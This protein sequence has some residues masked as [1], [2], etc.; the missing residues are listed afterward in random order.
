MGLFAA[1]PEQ[2][3]FCQLAVGPASRGPQA[4]SCPT[5][6]CWNGRDR[7]GRIDGDHPAMRDSAMN[8]AN[9]ARRAHPSPARLPTASSAS[10]PFCHTCQANQ[11]L[12]INLLATYL[13]DESDPAY[14]ERL[15]SLDAYRTSLYQR[16][17]PVCASCQPGVDA[18]LKRADQRA[19]AEAFGSALKRGVDTPRQTGLSWVDIGVWRARSV[20]WALDIFTAMGIGLCARAAPE[21]L[22]RIV[23]DNA[24][25]VLAIR[26][27]AILWAVWDPTWLRAARE[28]H[29]AQGRRAWVGIMLTLYLLRIAV[30]VGL[31]FGFPARWIT[32]AGALDITMVIAALT[33]RRDASRIQLTLVRPVHVETRPQPSQPPNH[34]S[35]SKAG[36]S[37]KPE[38]PQ[39]T[40]QSAVFGQPSLAL[41]EQPDEPMDWEPTHSDW[42]GFGVGTQRMFAP[43]ESNETGLEALLATWGLGGEPV[44]ERP[45][46][47]WERSRW[48]EQRKLVPKDS[49]GVFAI[50]QPAAPRDVLR[51]L[52]VARAALVA[53]RV[54]A[55]VAVLIRLRA[56]SA[57]KAL[58]GLEV[59]VSTITLGAALPSRSW[60]LALLAVDA[61]VRASVL[62]SPH[63]V[64]LPEALREQAP[65]IECVVWAVADAALL[66]A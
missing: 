19:Q 9:F 8:E 25:A 3:Y 7:A 52:W 62:L 24:P 26:V 11:T 46:S 28:G 54:A 64:P 30:V 29:P 31:V 20:A 6:G 37:S 65:A 51:P 40:R 4:W 66:L 15:A 18:G 43:A 39:P 13:P 14:S 61:G 53:L 57:L 17:P 33:R 35:H 42:D 27:A 56:D 32:A 55:L 34:S 60:S 49:H 38:P 63:L 41:P 21:T 48:G 5:C 22:Y 58:L 10:S 59:A 44:R 45:Q 47:A 23:Q 12:V 2:C 50:P 1:A 36:P 16:Y